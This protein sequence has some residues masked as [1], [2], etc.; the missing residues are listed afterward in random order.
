[1]LSDKQPEHSFTPT[2]FQV[3]SLKLK[4]LCYVREHAK[5]SLVLSE[6]FLLPVMPL[7]LAIFRYDCIIANFAKGFS[8]FSKMAEDTEPTFKFWILQP[9]MSKLS[10]ILVYQEVFY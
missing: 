7:K 3:W 9:F 5:S 8:W 1:M 4:R 10:A 2:T 6:C